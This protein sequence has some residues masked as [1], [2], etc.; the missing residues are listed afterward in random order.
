MA[1]RWVSRLRLQWLD[2]IEGEQGYQQVYALNG[3]GQPLELG[4]VYGDPPR[5]TK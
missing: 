5:P 4:G 1:G 2:F 3:I